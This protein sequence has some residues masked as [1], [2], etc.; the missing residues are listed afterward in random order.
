MSLALWSP[1]PTDTHWVHNEAQL[2]S[3]SVPFVFSGAGL[4]TNASFESS[5]EFHIDKQAVFYTD[6]NTTLHLSGPITSVAGSTQSLAKYGGERGLE[7]GEGRM[8]RIESGQRHRHQIG[9]ASC[10]G[11][12]CQYG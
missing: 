8:H 10:R 2:G 6:N 7:Q 9:R 1:P 11:R 4:Y 12:G 5:R 3:P